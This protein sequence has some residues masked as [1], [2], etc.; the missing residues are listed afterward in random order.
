ML[1]QAGLKSPFP[2]P[3]RQNVSFAPLNSLRFGFPFPC[4]GSRNAQTRVRRPALTAQPIGI[5][6]RFRISG[7]CYPSQ[8]CAHVMPASQ[9]RRCQPSYSSSPSLLRASPLANALP[10]AA[11][12]RG[13]VG[14]VGRETR[15]LPLVPRSMASLCGGLL[16]RQRGR[17]VGRPRPPKNARP[18]LHRHK[19]KC[20]RHR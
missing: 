11:F 6:P 7:I 15:P 4:A 20:C 9:C 1:S 14:C 13:R 12:G 17:P 18:P 10:A 19:D 8:T 3:Q 2:L 16:L 5:V